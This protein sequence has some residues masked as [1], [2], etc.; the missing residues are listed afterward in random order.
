[1]EKEDMESSE[2][3][4]VSKSAFQ[5]VRCACGDSYS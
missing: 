4:E 2:S 5:C 1:M 3:E